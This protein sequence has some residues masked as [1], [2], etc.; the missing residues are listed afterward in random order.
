MTLLKRTSSDNEDFQQLI[1]LLD[2]YLRIKDGDDHAFYA[3]Y[4]KTDSIKH[5]VVCY[6]E[7]VAVGC[8]AFKPYDDNRVEIKRMF[9]RPEH[10]GK[11]IGAAVL[12]ELERWAAEL[13]YASAILETGK[14]QVEAIRLYQKQGY[15]VIPNFTPYAGVDYSVCM[16]KAI[17]G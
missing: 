16:E 3:Q 6:D 8:G 9:V 2:A 5:V 17:S 14:G 12:K 7:G 13:H 1:P 10:R 11:G 15:T 4:N